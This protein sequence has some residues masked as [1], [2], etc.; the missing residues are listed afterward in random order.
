LRLYGLIFLAASF[1]A[2]LQHLHLY[3]TFYTENYKNIQWGNPLSALKKSIWYTAGF[4]FS[5]ADSSDDV[6][7]CDTT[8][9]NFCFPFCS[10][11]YY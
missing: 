10:L 5:A 11:V 9:I 1:D 7:D 3:I 4:V 8:S 2:N 6:V